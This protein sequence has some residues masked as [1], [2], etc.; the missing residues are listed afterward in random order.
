M[1]LPIM[2]PGLDRGLLRKW[3]QAIDKGPYSS[4]AF[5]ERMIFSNPE[6]MA[7]M[8]A[9]A[10]WTERVR[11]VTT[12]FIA[13]L[14][15]PLHL[16]KHIATADMLSNGRVTLGVGIG[17]RDEDYAALDVDLSMRQQAELARTVAA[18]R[19]VWAGDAG[20][21]GIE[22]TIGPRP[23]Q[24][25][26][27]PILSGAQGPKSIAA[28]AQWADG[29]SG[30]S[31]GPNLDEIEETFKHV[32]KQWAEA[33]RPKPRLNTAFW[34]ALGDDGRMQLDT[35][36]RRYIDWLEPE[37]LAAMFPYG[38]PG[39]A[40]SAS[41][42]KALLRQIEDTGADEVMLISTSSDIDQIAR[43]A[44]IIG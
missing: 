1:T 12:V 13:T 21:P 4:I 40:G 14:H 22:R 26:G 28:A 19:R 35:H 29:I 44:D 31:F 39:W 6:T 24:P 42:L 38:W 18:M 10:A 9:C 16:A 7:L 11:L 32:R 27:P 25:G 34:F 20:V 5:G 17:G 2:E 43:V 36:L 23:V 37:E 3:A 15:H 33:G 30:M 41:E 8:G